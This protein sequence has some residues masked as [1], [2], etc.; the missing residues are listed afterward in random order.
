MAI[1]KNK[2]TTIGEPSIGEEIDGRLFMGSFKL[3]RA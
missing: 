1:D 2:K 3:G